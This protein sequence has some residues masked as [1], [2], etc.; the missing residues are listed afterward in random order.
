[1]AKSKQF[2]VG[3]GNPL[4][5]EHSI[6]DTQFIESMGVTIC[7]YIV[8]YN[9]KKKDSEGKDIWDDKVQQEWVENPDNF[10]LKWHKI[11]VETSIIE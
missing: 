7:K 6:S 2:R 11:R 9:T 10:E 4:V 3:V 5:R 8:R 1:M